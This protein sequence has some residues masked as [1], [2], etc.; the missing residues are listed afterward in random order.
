MF[1]FEKGAKLADPCRSEQPEILDL[2]SRALKPGVTGDFL[3]RVVYH[4][5][6]E[7][8][9][10]TSAQLIAESGR[11]GRAELLA[12]KRPHSRRRRLSAELQNVRETSGKLGEA[13]GSSD[14]FELFRKMLHFGKI[15]KKF[16]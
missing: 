10:H 4:A 6:C 2:A 8:K 11:P 5:C 14:P 9:V 16:G 3:D 13:R 1:I 15:P 12:K 7:R